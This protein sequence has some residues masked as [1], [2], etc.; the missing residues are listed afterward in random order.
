M[1]STENPSPNYRSTMPLKWKENFKPLCRR[2][3][4]VTLGF[5]PMSALAY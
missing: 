3:K 2:L 1:H 4:I 5:H